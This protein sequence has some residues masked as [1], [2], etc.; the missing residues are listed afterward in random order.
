MII[1]SSFFSVSVVVSLKSEFNSS[2]A[3]AAVGGGERA[4]GHNLVVRLF[5]EDENISFPVFLSMISVLK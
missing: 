3:A 1:R 5:S 4:Q 2:T